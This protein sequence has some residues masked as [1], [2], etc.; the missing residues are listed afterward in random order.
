VLTYKGAMSRRPQG[1]TLVELM[2]TLAVAAI[3]LTIGVPVLR[4]FIL[5]NRLTT[6]ANTLA[7]SLALARA[8]AVRR[9]QPVAIVPVAGDWSK[10][11]TVGVD[12]NGDGIIDGE[13]VRSEGPAPDEVT[14]G[15]SATTAVVFRVSGLASRAESFRICDSRS[16]ETGREVDLLSTGRAEV[17]SYACP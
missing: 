4:D 13:V 6:H 1:I 16:G 17:K 5:N 11:W 2:V 9:N 15:A 10:G 12:A 7:A 8:E 3:L 14:V